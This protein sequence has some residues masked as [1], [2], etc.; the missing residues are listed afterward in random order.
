MAGC[1]GVDPRPYSV[2]KLFWMYEG[3]TDRED[4]H[5]R[6]LVASIYNTVST[7]KWFTPDDLKPKDLNAESEPMTGDQ[8]VSIGSS[9]GICTIG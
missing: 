2:R 8:V 4:D 3:R 6:Y 9:F 7:K 1:L 5:V